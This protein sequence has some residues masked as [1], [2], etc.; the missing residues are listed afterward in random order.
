M[1]QHIRK[2]KNKYTGQE[3][4]VPCGKCEACL[5][6][7]ADKRAMRIV[8]QYPDDG[9]TEMFFCTLTYDDR[10]IPYI[11]KSDIMLALECNNIDSKSMSAFI[12]Y[13]DE[14]PYTRTISVP[15]YRD[16]DVRWINATEERYNNTHRS[17]RRCNKGRF[18]IA[19]TVPC[20]VNSYRSIGVFC[21]D[22]LKNLSIDSLPCLQSDSDK[23]S[24][25]YY[26]DVQNFIK[27]L[28]I[29]LKRNGFTFPI[30]YFAASEY[31]NKTS[32]AH[33][34]LVF[35][36][37]K[38]F[39]TQLKRACHKAWTYDYRLSR[40][41][42]FEQATH[43]ASYVASYVNCGHNVP[44]LVRASKERPKVSYSFRFGTAKKHLSL[45]EVAKSFSRGDFRVYTEIVKD[46]TKSLFV[47]VLPQYV[48]RRYAPKCKGYC[49]L[50]T[51]SLYDIAAE[52]K[53]L[54]G[55]YKIL[56]YNSPKDCHRDMVMLY[57]KQKEWINAGFNR[58]DFALF[59]SHAWA[60][61]SSVS[62]SLSHSDFDTPEKLHTYYYN[63]VDYYTGDILNSALDKTI[64]Q[65]PKNFAYEIDPNK[66]PDVC[67]K[68]IKS[69]QRYHYY[70]KCKH[71][72][73]IAFNDAE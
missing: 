66:F 61:R 28:R 4:Y 63:I 67:K 51:D 32:R 30:S 35:F 34:H 19:R 60:L 16:F 14:D 24:V 18:Y 48:I 3:L 10:F 9:T 46:D 58:Y 39:Y 31:G 29:N 7:K 59:Y 70:K 53:K 40:R 25:C 73:A 55:Y 17:L 38:G 33:F 57:N 45:P 49:R 12:D 36:V 21:S 22:D 64:L 44:P 54:Y 11:R 23:I 13:S 27:R 2:I 52:P 65:L 5:Q 43:P 6:D 1:C 8:N 50:T 47:S 68:H 20:S 71:Q 42:K 56:G 15:I 72:N 37:P 62:Y 41:C 26:A 69:F